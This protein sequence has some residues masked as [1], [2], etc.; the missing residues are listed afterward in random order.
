MRSARKPNDP[1]SGSETVPELPR[2]SY[3]QFKVLRHVMDLKQAN[4]SIFSDQSRRD[5][6]H[7]QVLQEISIWLQLGWKIR[8]QIGKT[9]NSSLIAYL[10]NLFIIYTMIDVKWH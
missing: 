2:L 6:T 9:D 10:S 5:P 4:K 7:L 8:N 1:E 3:T